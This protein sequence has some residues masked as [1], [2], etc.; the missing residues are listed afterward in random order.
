MC[1]FR[2]FQSEIFAK[3]LSSI[4][5]RSF[6]DCDGAWDGVRLLIIFIGSLS[7]VHL[8]SKS[9]PGVLEDMDDCD[10]AWDGVRVLIISIE[11]FTERFVKIQHQVLYL[12]DLC[13]IVSI[14]STCTW[15]NGRK[16]GHWTYK[17]I[18]WIQC[19]FCVWYWILCLSVY[20]T[21]FSV[22]LCMILDLVS[23][24]G[25]QCLQ[26]SMILHSR[27]SVFLWQWYWI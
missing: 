27:V 13:I 16:G 23:F 7:R 10:G 17:L 11:S 12:K 2:N 20:N 15:K 1:N 25:F 5:I 24:S 9:L 22:F 4:S 26:M 19:F 8:S 3:L 18:I 21:T 14:V 6:T